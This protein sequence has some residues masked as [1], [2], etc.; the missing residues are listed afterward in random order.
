MENN[1]TFF[2]SFF[3]SSLGKILCALN[4]CWNNISYNS[5]K[6]YK[7]TTISGN[8]IDDNGTD[9]DDSGDAACEEENKKEKQ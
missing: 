9:V 7:R 6:L 5:K 3:L 4:T 8:Y 2:H 1:L